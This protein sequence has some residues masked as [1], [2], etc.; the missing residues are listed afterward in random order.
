MSAAADLFPLWT[1]HRDICPACREYDEFRPATAAKLCQMGSGLLK[2]YIEA[3]NR[4]RA[5]LVNQR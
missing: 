5:E 3:S 1:N 2:R 4:E